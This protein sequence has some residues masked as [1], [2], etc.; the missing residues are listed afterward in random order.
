MIVF[1]ILLV[2][3]PFSAIQL[4][5]LKHF[6]FAYFFKLFFVLITFHFQ[7]TI[8]EYFHD[9]YYRVFYYARYKNNSQNERN[10]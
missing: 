3:L 10:F 7:N 5:S 2:F 4:K 1:L 9:N 6:F 8:Y